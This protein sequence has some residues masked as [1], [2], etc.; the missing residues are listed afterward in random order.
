MQYSLITQGETIY[1]P[2]MSFCYRVIGSICRLYDRE[3]LPYPSCSLQWRGKQPSWN[4]VGKRF[5]P[6]MSCKNSP[7][8][9]V[10]LMNGRVEFTEKIITC[11][12][13]KLSPEEKLWWCTP[14]SKMRYYEHITTSQELYKQIRQHS[15]SVAA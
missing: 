4:R 10:Y 9:S 15:T 12:W 11:N 6:D 14:S 7:S 5:I 8:Y 1:S 3:E 2:G 13:V